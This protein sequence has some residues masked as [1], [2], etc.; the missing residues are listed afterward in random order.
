VAVCQLCIFRREER[1]N[2]GQKNLDLFFTKI[3]L[4][5]LYDYVIQMVPLFEGALLDAIDRRHR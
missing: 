4:S 1:E 5:S 2:S 3:E